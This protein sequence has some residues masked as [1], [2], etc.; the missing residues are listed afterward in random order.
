MTYDTSYITSR[1]RAR[2]PSFEHLSN[3]TLPRKDHLRKGRYPVEPDLA[4]IACKY[5]PYDLVCRQG[6]RLE[7]RKKLTADGETE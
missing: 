5:C 6:P 2:Y 3:V 7:W 1:Y 4:R